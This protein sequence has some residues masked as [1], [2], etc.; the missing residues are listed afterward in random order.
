[1]FLFSH[2]KF[3]C[4][5]LTSFFQSLEITDEVCDWF[6]NQRSLKELQVKGRFHNSSNESV[7]RFFLSLPDSLTHLTIFAQRYINDDYEREGEHDTNGQTN[8]MDVIGSILSSN[9]NLQKL[10][11]HVLPLP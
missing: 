1:M 11:V 4:H 2:F 7:K 10:V 6:G 8:K 9:P 3:L 5:A